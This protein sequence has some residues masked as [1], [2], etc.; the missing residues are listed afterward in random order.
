MSIE[1]TNIETLYSGWA[2]YLLATARLDDGTSIRR[3]VEAH[4]SAACV[5]PYD[6]MRGTAILVRQFRMPVFLTTGEPETLEAIAGILEEPDPVD[7]A[8]REALEE[9]G[10]RIGKLEPV[11][12]AWTMPGISTERLYLYL[13]TYG[14]ADRIA[15]GGGLEAEAE[16]TTAIEMRLVELA[17]LADAGALT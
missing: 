13:A 4:G 11:T 9:A 1:I 16:N 14:P 10:V 12:A 8:R 17:G 3:E 15:R 7:C 2:R 5:L 6:P